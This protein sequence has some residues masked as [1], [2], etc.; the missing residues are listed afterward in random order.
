LNIFWVIHIVFV[1]KNFHK[2]IYRIYF[3]CAFF[4][5]LWT[6]SNAYFQSNL[7]FL[8]GT[9]VA[10]FMAL[11]A[12]LT[13]S[14]AGIGF[15]SMACLFGN[16]EKKFSLGNR[17]FITFLVLQNLL[18]N[19]IPNLTVQDVKIFENGTFELIFGQ[20]NDV[21]FAIGGLIILLAFIKFSLAIRKKRDGIQN[22]KF[23]YILFGMSL[24]YGSIIVFSII[25]PT[26]FENFDYVWIPP[27]LSI[28]D[29]LITG[30]GV[31]VQRFSSLKF[32]FA[33]LLK[34][35]VALALGVGAA[36]ATWFIFHF[37]FR[38]S[39]WGFVHIASI[40]SLLFVYFQS[41][42]LF[43]SPLFY[44]FFGTTSVEHFQNIISDFQKQNTIYTTLQEFKEDLQKKFC[45]QLGIS[46]VQIIILDPDS[47]KLYPN[48]AKYCQIYPQILITKEIQFQK[49]NEKKCFSFWNELNS[50]G[51]VFLPLYHP[52]QTLIGFFILGKKP[53]DKIYSKEEIEAIAQARSYLSLNLTGI[54]FNS[55]LHQEVQRKTEALQEQNKAMQLQNEQINAQNRE[56]GN[57]LAHKTKLLA[58]QSDF[59][60]LTAHELRT[61]LAIAMLHAEQMLFTP[62]VQKAVKKQAG[63]I[64]RS[65]EKLKNL[66]D[67]LFEVLQYDLNKINITPEE[68][69][70][71]EFI[72]RVFEDFQ[73]FMKEK[74]LHFSLQNKIKRASKA[75]FDP[76]YMRQLMQNLLTNA[77][78]FTPDNGKVILS[79]KEDRKFFIFQVADSGEG[80]PEETKEEIFKKFKSNHTM[81]SPG[82]GLGLYVCKKIIELHKG[83]IWVED[84]PEGG[85]I[86]IVE[87]PK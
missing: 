35:A 12:N 67:K 25:L 70:V 2:R 53:L 45:H 78:K 23:Y 86:F 83:K 57:L 29:V 43:R 52:S 54:L 39:S 1:K 76:I 66:M 28:F 16:P 59:I 56:I 5:L 77:I 51:E 17:V 68:T 36:W 80:V 8:L 7:L 63:G 38:E 33:N 74:N 60:A 61:P 13:A 47:E 31:L 81:Q 42:R 49:F 48:L 75:F 30:Y 6:L 87:I 3:S 40:I 50:L 9:G 85:A 18:F 79:A 26:F 20:W 62:G 44:R 27:I 15:Y 14:F 19:F 34:A 55:Q 71:V 24:M 65:L 11:L 58:Q 73:P 46:S 84:N 64:Q 10:K 82:I 21:F 69:D 41:F 22:V 32:V 37:I 4:A 72:E